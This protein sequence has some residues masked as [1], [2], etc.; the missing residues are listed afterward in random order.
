MTPEFAAGLRDFLLGAL[1]SEVSATSRVV[2]AIPEDKGDYAPDPKATPALKLGFHIVASEIWFFDS[3]AAGSFGGF[4]SDE[5]P[6]TPAAVVA[7]WESTRPASRAKVA[8]MTGEQLA[9]IVDFYGMFQLPAAAYLNFAN[10]HCIHHRG[11]LASY[12]R[13]MGSKVPSIYGGSADEP[14]A[15]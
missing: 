10:V 9:G 13:P 6:I 4:P 2:M 5:P 8:A 1:D 3:I 12:L 7:W 15:G 11:Q 14:M